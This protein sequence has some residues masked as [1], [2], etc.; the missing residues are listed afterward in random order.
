MYSSIR[1]PMAVTTDGIRVILGVVP[2]AR[3]GAILYGLLLARQL[4]NSNE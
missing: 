1:L 4:N 2:V 3:V